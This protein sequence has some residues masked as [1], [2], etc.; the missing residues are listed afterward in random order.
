MFAPFPGWQTMTT[1]LTSLI[2]LTYLTGATSTLAMRHRLPNIYRPF[3]LK[4]VFLISLLGVFSSTLVFLWSGWEIVSKSGIAICI[5]IFMLGAYRNFGADK[6]EKISW[7]FKQSIWFWFYII[8][9]SIVSYLSD[10]GGIGLLDFYSAAAVLLVVSFIT[11]I[12]AKQYCLAAD[13]MQQGIDMA[14]QQQNA[15]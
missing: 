5:A 11:C 13:E 9:V 14:L 3:K 2:S 6:L 12:I 7:H 4:G 10:F 15:H 8:A 1:F